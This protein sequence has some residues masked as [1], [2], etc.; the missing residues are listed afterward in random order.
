MVGR[1]NLH[2]EVILNFLLSSY[3]VGMT[4]RQNA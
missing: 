1:L 2:T 4:D 3:G